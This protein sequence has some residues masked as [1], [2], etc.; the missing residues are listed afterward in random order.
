MYDCN[1]E[2]RLGIGASVP[3]L[4]NDYDLTSSVALAVCVVCITD[5]VHLLC[6]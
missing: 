4:D 2:C 1:D 3:G 5:V 6:L